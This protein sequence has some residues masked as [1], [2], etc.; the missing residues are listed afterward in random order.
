M[1]MVERALLKLG[2][3]QFSL[4]GPQNNHWSVEKGRGVEEIILSFD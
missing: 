1:E 4:Q 3:M 2:R